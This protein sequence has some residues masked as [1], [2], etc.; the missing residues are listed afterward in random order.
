MLILKTHF[1]NAADAA[2]F[3]KMAL[4]DFFACFLYKNCEI[5]ILTHDTV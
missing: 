1:L 5:V 3:Q 4:Y 2:F